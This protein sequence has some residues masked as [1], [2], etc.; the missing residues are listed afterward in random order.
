[1]AETAV[2]PLDLDTIA[3]ILA[4]QQRKEDSR[5]LPSKLE[6]HN[7]DKKLLYLLKMPDGAERMHV[8]QKSTLRDSDGFWHCIACGAQFIKDRDSHFNWHRR[9]LL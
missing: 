2:K 7:F 4:D 5:W 3:S 8:P 6:K 9:E 1:M